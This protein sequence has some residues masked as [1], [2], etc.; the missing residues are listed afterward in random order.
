MKPISPITPRRRVTVASVVATALVP[1]A[2]AGCGGSSSTAAKTPT[3]VAPDPN[4]VVT[5]PRVARA[6]AAVYNPRIVPAD[7]THTITNPYF[8]LTPGSIRITK[9]TKDGVPQT[10]TTRVTTDTRV[11]AGVRCVVVSDNVTTNGALSEKVTDWYAQDRKGNVWYFGEATADY[12]KGV[13]TTTKGSWLT[14]VDGAKPGIVMPA[15]P[16]PG[17]SY[18]SEFRPG[19]AE[20]KGQVLR[21]DVALTV[22]Y[23]SYHNVVVIRDTNPLDPTLISHKWY[24][25]GVGLL[26]TVR[27]GSSH[28][29][30]AELVQLKGL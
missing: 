6:A 22:P 10:H 27:V 5:A 25:K 8:K 11:V 9:G 18:Y 20:D 7:F 3:A 2:F 14:G 12:E 23:G 17:P 26:K 24:A 28:K 19:V 13:V 30:H 29:E 21:T 15:N 16:T 4:G 1:A